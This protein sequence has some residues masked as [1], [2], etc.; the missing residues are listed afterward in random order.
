[1]AQ[2]V[3]SLSPKQITERIQLHRQAVMLFARLAAKKAVRDQLRDQGVRVSLVPPAE[4]VRQAREYLAAH[5]E[6]YQQATERAQRM[7]YVDPRATNNG[8][9]HQGTSSWGSVWQKA[10]ANC[11]STT[12]GVGEK[13]EWRG[14]S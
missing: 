7:G 10:K 13:G 9:A 5:P 8:R 14:V 2:A 3:R 6:L 11:A 1:M 12:R 4:I